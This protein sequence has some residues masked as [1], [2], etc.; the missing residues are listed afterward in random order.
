[1]PLN[2]QCLKVL[3][4]NVTFWYSHLLTSFHASCPTTLLFSYPFHWAQQTLLLQQSPSFHYFMLKYACVWNFSC[5]S[6]LPIVLCFVQGYHG[7]FLLAFSPLLYSPAVW[8]WPEKALQAGKQEL[9]L[10]RRW[11]S[12]NM[13]PW[14]QVLA[15]VSGNTRMVLHF[16]K[17]F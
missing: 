17:L 7:G 13:I 2:P 11:W 10:G 12:A 6:C 3:L 15:V 4:C 14:H 9:V 1:M 8:H 16:L 5:K